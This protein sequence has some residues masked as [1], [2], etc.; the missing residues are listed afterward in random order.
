MC[1]EF[2]YGIG[3]TAASWTALFVPIIVFTQKLRPLDI[4]TEYWAI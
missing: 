4:V 1:I 2:I 3:T